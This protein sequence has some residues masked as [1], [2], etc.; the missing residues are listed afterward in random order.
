MTLRL[1]NCIR[2]NGLQNFIWRNIT[3]VSS[4]PRRLY[5]EQISF[6]PYKD[7]MK[8]IRTEQRKTDTPQAEIV[9]GLVDEALRARR[10][11]QLGS[12]TTAKP[13]QQL[14]KEALTDELKP[15]KNS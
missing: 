12:D 7:N 15:L 10:L 1:S 8:E 6:H 11:R 13:Y 3:L 9:R 4:K 5:A 14:A 2:S